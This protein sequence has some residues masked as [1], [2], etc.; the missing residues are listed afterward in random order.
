MPGD[1]FDLDLPADTPLRRAAVCA[2][3]PLLRWALRLDTLHELYG[4][5]RQASVDDATRSRPGSFAAT[6]LDILD[7]SIDCDGAAGIP[8]EGPLIVAANH[9]LGALDG[10]ALLDVIGRVRRDVR[11]VANHFLGCVPELRELCFFVDPFAA[12]DSSRR[13]LAGLRAAHLWLRRGGALIIFPAGEVAHTLRADGSLV[14]ASWQPT[15]GRLALSTSARVLPVHIDGTN[16]ALFY[17]AGRVHP[18]LR[19]LLLARELLNRRG[20]PVSVRIGRVLPVTEFATNDAAAPALT[21]RIR[22]AVEEI[23]SQ[24]PSMSQA[25]KPLAAAIDPVDLDEDV[26]Q[27]PAAAKLLAAGAFDVYCAEAAQMPSVLAEI[28][29][30]RESSFRAVG[31]GTG[32]PS[33]IDSF[34]RR[35]LHLFV[36]N[37]QAREVVGAYRIGR[38]DEI[39]A[40]SGVEGLYTRTLFAYDH[41]LFTRLPPALELGRSFVRT[42]YQRDHSALLLLWKGICTF[43]RRHPHYRLLLGAVSISARYTDRTRA[44]LMQFLEQNYRDPELAELVASLHPYSPPHP[45]R[46]GAAPRT[47]GEADALAARFE[48]GSGMPVLLRQYLKL[49]ARL[50]GFNVDPAFGDALDALMMVDLLDVDVRILRRFFGAEGARTFLAHHV[51]SA[52]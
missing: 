23:R 43:V 27:L 11:L 14:D 52:A 41:R 24:T 3:R 18:L 47:I 48:S 17:A 37:R 5:A 34:D 51:A 4:K 21:Q 12:H 6:A 36:W 8:T 7:V 44:M 9:P 50:L 30:L 33:D 28:G 22:S 45:A 31:E 35:Y 32:E 39:I 25:A 15:I 16:S 49:N 42:E 40:S 13:S 19:T 46:A 1:S 26:R 29:R 20:R 2:A 38:V 10:L